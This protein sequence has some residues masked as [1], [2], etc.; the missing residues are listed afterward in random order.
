MKNMSGK[1]VAWLNDALRDY[2]Y[3]PRRWFNP[4]RIVFVVMVA[5]I[6]SLVGNAFAHYMVTATVDN[7]T[8]EDGYMARYMFEVGAVA[9]IVVA[10]LTRRMFRALCSAHV[11]RLDMDDAIRAGGVKPNAS[12]ADTKSAPS[13]SRGY[14]GSMNGDYVSTVDSSEGTISE[15]EG[16]DA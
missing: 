5:F 1:I 2:V 8:F 6:A 7:G 13:R 11:R 3:G 16:G 15:S 9:F 4:L 12:D 10:M 14:A